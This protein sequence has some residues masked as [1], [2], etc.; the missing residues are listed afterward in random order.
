MRALTYRLR[1]K[2]QK[3]LLVIIRTSGAYLLFYLRIY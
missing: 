2:T 1:A 3:P